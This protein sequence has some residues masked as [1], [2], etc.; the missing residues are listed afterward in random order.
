MLDVSLNIGSQLSWRG[1]KSI[2]VTRSL[3]QIA[4]TFELSLTDR[5]S[6][7]SEAAYFRPGQSCQVLADGGSLIRGFVDDLDVNVS[8]QQHEIAVNGRDRTADLVDCSVDD[9]P[10]EWSGVTVG[11]IIQ[12]ICS[13]LGIEVVDAAA[14]TSSIAKFRVEQGETAF[15]TIERAARLHGL[16]VRSDEVGRV[17]IERLTVNGGNR[18]DIALVY[19]E[20]IE[21]AS[22]R[23]SMRER[24]SAYS[25]K[26]HGFGSDEGLTSEINEP[27]GAASDPNVGRYR[28]LTVLAEDQGGASV[29][30]ERAQWEASVRAARAKRAEVTV[31]GWLD[32][33]GRTWQPGWLVD[34]SIPSLNIEGNMRIASARFSIDDR[35]GAVTSLSLASPGSFVPAPAVAD[36]E[37]DWGW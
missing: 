22:A 37:E 13:P 30:E 9:E 4:G 17:V 25:V 33:M 18:H 14:D 20:N 34:C 29:F 12:D 27:V 32:G 3:E 11:K 1:W 7:T 24:F 2:V 10:G 19:G 16:I 8:D 6:E 26:G 21:Q 31:T 35:A 15:T 28:P 36:E 23:F 5:W